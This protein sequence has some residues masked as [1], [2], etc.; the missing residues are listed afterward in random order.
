M[1]TH[2]TSD[3]WTVDDKLGYAEYARA[4]YHFLNDPRTEPPLTISIQAPWGDGKTS[5]M[6]MVQEQLD[7]KGYE[8]WSGAKRP[9]LTDTLKA[10]TRSVI[11]E[12]GNLANQTPTP[13]QLDLGSVSYTHLTLPTKR[14]V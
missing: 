8:L 9:S 13:I 10:T 5:L 12:L 7:P 3:L 1:S 11:D 2:T 4:I 14:I 6:R